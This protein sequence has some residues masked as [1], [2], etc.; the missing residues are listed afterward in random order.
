M[1]MMMEAHPM[2]QTQ[3]MLDLNVV[4][5]V[6]TTLLSGEGVKLGI[7]FVTRVAC[8]LAFVENLDLCRS[9][10]IKFVR[11]LNTIPSKYPI[12]LNSECPAC[13][14]LLPQRQVPNII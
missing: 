3:T 12:S 8:M 14:F 6:L 5:V 13:F 7:S 11:D 2:N 9:R 10:E 4:T 1:Q